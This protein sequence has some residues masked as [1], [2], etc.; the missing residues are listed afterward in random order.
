MVLS[1]GWQTRPL[2]EFGSVYLLLSFFYSAKTCHSHGNSVYPSVSC[3]TYTP[4]TDICGMF[5]YNSAY[6][7]C[8]VSE[9]RVWNHMANILLADSSS[10]LFFI[11]LLGSLFYVYRWFS[12]FSLWF[13]P[14]S[15]LLF[16]LFIII[17]ISYNLITQFPVFENSPSL[18]ITR[19]W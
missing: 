13:F 9:L 14:V 18:L 10:K 7:Q 12:P 5:L 1:S 6:S 16:I 19:L 15:F 8:W 11:I 4:S 3:T 2:T 17:I